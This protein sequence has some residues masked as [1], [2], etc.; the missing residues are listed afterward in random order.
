MCGCYL[1]KSGEG[2]DDGIGRQFI[3]I[4]SSNLADGCLAQQ[5]ILGLIFQGIKWPRLGTKTSFFVGGCEDE[6]DLIVWVDVE[7]RS[8]W[9]IYQISCLMRYG[10][11]RL[12]PSHS[13]GTTSI[14][15][16][17]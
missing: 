7:C 9:N 1:W 2:N 13:K 8:M 12:R 11:F 17:L 15:R 4:L 5:T 10:L 6:R 14:L 16:K 3:E